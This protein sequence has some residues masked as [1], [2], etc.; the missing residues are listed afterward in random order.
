[1]PQC[2]NTRQ[3]RPGDA[4]TMWRI[5]QRKASFMH[6]LVTLLASLAQFCLEF[7]ACTRDEKGNLRPMWPSVVAKLGRLFSHWWLCCYCYYRGISRGLITG[8]EVALICESLFIISILRVIGQLMRLV[9][10]TQMQS[11]GGQPWAFYFSK[12]NISETSS[13]RKRQKA[14][15]TGILCLSRDPFLPWRL[16]ILYSYFPRVGISI[17]SEGVDSWPL[18]IWS[19]SWTTAVNK[20]LVVVVVL[21]CVD[22]SRYN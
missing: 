16:H 3:L 17:V 20:G 11:T 18:T 21:W 19:E 8:T 7:R 4:G 12:R 2:N 15:S 5:G 6:H 14:T 13:C 10:W 22:G 1:M 9:S